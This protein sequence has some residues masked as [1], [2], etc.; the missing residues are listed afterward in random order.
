MRRLP[1]SLTWPLSLGLYAAVA[2]LPAWQRLFADTR[3]YATFAT[4]ARVWQAG[5]DPYDLAALQATAPAGTT[6]YPFFYP[7]PALPLLAWTGWLPLQAGYRV[8]FWLNELALAGVLWVLWRWFRPPPWLLLLAACTWVPVGWSGRLGQV[9]VV[10]LLLAVAALWRARGGLLAAAAVIKMSPAL[11]A[12]PWLARRR[13]RPLAG[14]VLGALAAH[15]LVLPWVPL[16]MQ[17]HFYLEVLP[18]FASGAY[19]GIDVPITLPANHSLANL[20]DQ[21]WPGPDDHHLSTTAA[22]LTRGLIGSGLLALLWVGRRILT[23]LGDALLVGALLVLMTIAPVFTYEHHL[24]FLLPAAVAAATAIHRGLLPRSALILLI[25]AWL[26]VVLPIEEFR[27]L[28]RLWPDGA[29]F[30]RESKLLGALALGALCAWGAGQ[31]GEANTEQ[32]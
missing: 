4:A 3:D 5:G 24:V 16:S 17:Q 25:P 31:L 19:N 26:A 6:V 20:L 29:A 18:Q 27:R 21:V 11:L 9:N 7:P 32:R 2:V 8:M 1:P 30:V 10:V 28:Q 13:W 23:A 14:A 12:A 22:M 15:I